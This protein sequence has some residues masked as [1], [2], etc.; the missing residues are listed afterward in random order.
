MTRHLGLDLGGTN[1]KMVVLEPGADGIPAVV[2]SR[3]APT[4][5]AG[6]PEAVADQLVALGRSMIEDYG[7]VAG[8]GL[9]V[10]GLFDRDSGAIVLFPN[11]PGPWPGYP[12]RD[13]V[14]D[15]VGVPVS[16]INDARAFTLAE[17]TIG[18]GR[19]CRVLVCLTLGTG[20]GG[21]IMI[22]GR[23]HLGSSGRA[24]EIAHQ[25]ILPD[26]PL[27]GCGNRG[28]VEAVTRADVLLEQAGRATVEDVYLGVQ[29]GDER[30]LAAVAQVSEY[31]GIAIANTITLIGP[32]RVV[33]GGGI[34]QAGE[35]ALDPIRKAVWRHV[36]LVPAASVDIV[37]A[38]L[39]SQAGAIGAALAG[40]GQ[41]PVRDR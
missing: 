25:I 7:P 28:C 17:G 40:S 9:G 30:C 22:D 2:A 29:A 6:G 36:T 34:A 33:V 16:L 5:A 41:P 15:G 8:L 32:E 3:T 21:G 10:P 1:V 35:L 23:L 38:S 13:R 24:G 12:L 14:G 11:L 4:G 18:A 31:L 39:G 19:G 27:C 26:G 37:A 20:V